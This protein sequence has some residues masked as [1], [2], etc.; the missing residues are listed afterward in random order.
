MFT[1]EN[2]TILPMGE[3]FLD[4][5]TGQLSSHSLPNIFIKKKS[6]II[7]SMVPVFNFL[8]KIFAL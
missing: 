1:E 8:S 6:I 5:Y 2:S 4:A 7:F 3:N